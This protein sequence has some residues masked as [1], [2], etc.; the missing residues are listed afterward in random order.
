[1]ACKGCYWRVLPQRL[2]GQEV[3]RP[4]IRAPQACDTDTLQGLDHTTHAPNRTPFSTR[5]A[6][7]SASL[8][9]PP[10]G[11]ICDAPAGC[12]NR[13]ASMLCPAWRQRKASRLAIKEF[14]PLRIIAVHPQSCQSPHPCWII[15]VVR[16]PDLCG[17]CWRTAQQCRHS[18]SSLGTQMHHMRRRDLS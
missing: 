14:S 8:R 15:W 10:N 6:P 2:R 18:S 7:Q 9:P 1:M 12:S 13:S 11:S 3:V 4:R 17:L 16:C 5:R